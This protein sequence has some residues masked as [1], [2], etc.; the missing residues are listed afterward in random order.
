MLAYERERPMGSSTGCASSKR[1]RRP[2]CH[3]CHVCDG[4]LDAE[5]GGTRSHDHD[6]I[7][8]RSRSKNYR[9]RLAS[10]G[11]FEPPYQG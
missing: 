4:G 9:L 10:P 7:K 5:D 2:W 3:I 1:G 11:G 6:K 8:K